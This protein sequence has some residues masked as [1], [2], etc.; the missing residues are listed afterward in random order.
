MDKEKE[1]KNSK[2]SLRVIGI[3]GGGFG[4]ILATIISLIIDPEMLY[5]VDILILPDMIGVICFPIVLVIF[6]FVFGVIG[7][8]VGMKRKLDLKKS[9]I[10]GFTY[11][12]G[13]VAA[14]KLF[15]FVFLSLG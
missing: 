12:F 10:Y 11:G 9:F 14:C 15:L 8:N 2:V 7:G 6:G 3:F 1:I 4:A 13:S 5:V